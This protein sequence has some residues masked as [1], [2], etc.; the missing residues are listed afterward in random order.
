MRLRESSP[1]SPCKSTA[2]L[3]D[4]ILES[5]PAAGDGDSCVS[6]ASAMAICRSPRRGE[7]T[8]RTGRSRARDTVTAS[9]L[10]VPATPSKPSAAPALPRTRADAPCPSPAGQLAALPAPARRPPRLSRRPPTSLL[11]LPASPS[12]PPMDQEDARSSPEQD[13]DPGASRRP[14][15]GPMPLKRGTACKRCR[16]VPAARTSSCAR[17][18][19]SPGITD[20]TAPALAPPQVPEDRELLFDLSNALLA[21]LNAWLT[22]SSLPP[23]S[24]AAPAS[25]LSAACA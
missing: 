11:R 13:A 18:P 14:S 20:T 10:P 25:A 17:T 4:R 1:R 8:R 12:A 15:S 23:A 24:S 2:A 22:L 7:P 21:L 16:S 19:S 5:A 9:S 3:S 6:G